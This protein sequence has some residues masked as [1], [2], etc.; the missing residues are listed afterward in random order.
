MK[1]AIGKAGIG[2]IV[3][4]SLMAVPSAII[5]LAILGVW[6][7]K[8]FH[9]STKQE[10]VAEDFFNKGWLPEFIPESASNICVTRNID[11]GTSEGR[12]EIN[13]KDVETF[14]STLSQKNTKECTLG[15][16]N[17]YE[18]LRKNG[19][20]SVDCSYGHTAWRFMINKTTG[21]CQYASSMFKFK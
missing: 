1:K 20:I 9:Y 12:F 18:D 19:Y 21:D 13:P 14:I 11:I 7:I 17:N 3:L 6:D 5:I 16:P 2:T 8:E 4:V 15:Q 10:A